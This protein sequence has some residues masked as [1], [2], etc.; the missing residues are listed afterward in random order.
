MGDDERE[1]S[2]EEF[3]EALRQYLPPVAVER[4]GSIE[5]QRRE[6]GEGPGPGEQG[7]VEA[8]LAELG[9]DY[10]PF[11]AWGDAFLAAMQQVGAE[12][13]PAVFARIPRPPDEPPAL[14]DRLLLLAHTPGAAGMSA[15]LLL[16]T[17]ACAR[18]VRALK[19]R[20]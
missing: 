13:F 16:H 7:S 14:W 20:A 9:V 5:D 11:Q 15:C 3:A 4:L 17:L 18:A 8:V 1:V 10:S 2:G 6:M 19:G 12:P